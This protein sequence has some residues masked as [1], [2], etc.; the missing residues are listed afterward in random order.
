VFKGCFQDIQRTVYQYFY[1]LTRGL[2]TPCYP[3][4]G[5]VKYVIH[6][7]C[8]AIH[9][10]GITD[11]ALDDVYTSLIESPRQITPGP[12]NKVVDYPDFG[13]SCGQKLID[14][15][16]SDKSSSACDEAACAC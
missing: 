10:G 11:I 13:N 7:L 6:T 3:Q 8:G 4:G 9:K 15:G 16:A 2:C 14:N 5:L 1:C 12:T